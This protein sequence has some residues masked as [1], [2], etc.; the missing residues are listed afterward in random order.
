VFKRYAELLREND[1]PDISVIKKNVA[2]TEK[3][4]DVFVKELSL[5]AGVN[6][7]PYF[8]RWGFP[9]N[10]SINKELKHLPKAKLFK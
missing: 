2:E 1:Y 7:Y 5:A 3:K 4:V 10:E 9:V 6:F 8:D